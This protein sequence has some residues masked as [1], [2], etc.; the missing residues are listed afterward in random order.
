M[1]DKIIFVIISLTVVISIVGL[2]YVIIKK[3][4]DE[5]KIKTRTLFIAIIVIGLLLITAYLE[6]L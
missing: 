6:R 2:F 4:N 5:V 1:W 3:P